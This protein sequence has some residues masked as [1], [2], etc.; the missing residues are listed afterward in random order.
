MDL[1]KAKYI[2]RYFSKLMNQTEAAAVRHAMYSNKLEQTPPEK[3]ERFR[4]MFISRGLISEHPEVTTLLKNGYQS[5]LIDIAGRIMQED[6][7]KVS[8]N[9]CPA[10]GKLTRTPKARQCRHCGNDWHQAATH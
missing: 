2:V 1:E 9:N 7:D 5:M 3:K 10:C 4:K 8:F 6:G